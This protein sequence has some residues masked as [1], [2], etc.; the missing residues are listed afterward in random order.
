MTLNEFLE[1][2][3]YGNVIILLEGKR[4]VN[5]DDSIKLEEI[6][7][8]LAEKLPLAHFRSGNAP[9]ADELFAKGVCA[10]DPERFHVV[11]PFSNH[12]SKVR[13]KIKFY[14]VE[15]FA[16]TFNEELIAATRKNRK[17]SH[18]VDLYLK[19]ERNKYTNKVAYIMR[20]SVKVLGFNHL[21]PTTVALFYDDLNCP[22][23]GGTGFTI[24]TCREH[25][26]PLFKQDIWMEW[27]LGV[28]V[29]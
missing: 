4:D 17:T 29:Y 3:N 9:G 6:G 27:L 13:E 16:P 24:K 10:I 15:D 25:Q 8:L 7:R 14:S 5:P 26:I 1:S 28:G 23:D 2:Y 12:R 21:P 22:E 11:V 20:N 18:L 19:G